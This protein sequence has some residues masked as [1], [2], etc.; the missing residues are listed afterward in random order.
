MQADATLRPGIITIKKIGQEYQFI[1]FDAKY[2]VPIL[3]SG[4]AP[5]GQPGI[6]SIT[7]Q[8]LYQL[9]YKSFIEDHGFT[10]VKN[11]FLMPTENQFVIDYKEVSLNMLSFLE[12][13]DIKVRC[14]PA[15]IE[16]PIEKGIRQVLVTQYKDLYKKKNKIKHN[17]NS[18]LN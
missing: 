7:K 16:Y 11:C 12:L 5:K 1:I 18:C 9:A 13:Q 2:Y 3:K 4:V 15:E 17:C 8:Y 10:D 6:E 14:I